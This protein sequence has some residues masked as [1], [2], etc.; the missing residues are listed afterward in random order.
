MQ[1]APGALKS[2]RPAPVIPIVMM[3]MVA[4]EEDA[5]LRHQVTPSPTAKRVAQ[6]GNAWSVNPDTKVSRGQVLLG[7]GRS[8]SRTRC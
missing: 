2:A 8:A 5:A 4:R 1:R 3:G 7:A 6:M